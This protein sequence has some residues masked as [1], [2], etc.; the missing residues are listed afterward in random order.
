[1]RILLALLLTACASDAGSMSWE[2]GGPLVPL[3]ISD[4]FCGSDGLHVLDFDG[5]LE[6]DVLGGWECAGSTG[7]GAVT[8]HRRWR[9]DVV[10]EGLTGIEGVR[11]CDVTGDGQLDVIAAGETGNA[12]LCTGSADLETW[13]CGVLAG[14][15]VSDRW[16]TIACGDLDADGDRDL[17][18]GGE[19]S[20]LALWTNPG[21]TAADPATWTRTDI[22]TAVKHV[23][24]IFIEDFDADLDQ[25][26]FVSMR[27]TLPGAPNPGRVVWLE[28]GAAWVEHIIRPGVRGMIAC[29]GDLDADGDV[30][31][32]AP[33]EYPA[34]LEWYERDGLTWIT[35]VIPLDPLLVP[36]RPKGC[37]LAD[38]DADG[39]LDL[40]LTT[41]LGG[42]LVWVAERQGAAWT[43]IQASPLNYGQKYEEPVWADIDG[44]LPLDLVLSE[45][46]MMRGLF[47][48]RGVP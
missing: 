16:L 45:E 6:L 1:M 4:D 3:P 28:N 43:W 39:D 12:L 41:Q 36:T 44:A 35:H 47:W 15:S 26:F 13:T 38:A 30:D 2:L 11:A 37:D 9:T 7:T 42:R 27:Y 31:Y 17:V 22:S 29:R 23:M 18:V 10:A 19:T 21:A 20:R 32:A 34:G 25:D 48:L 46:Q 24:R 33:L 14:S 8:L 40:A 5:D